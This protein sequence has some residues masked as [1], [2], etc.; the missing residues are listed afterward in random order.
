M[1]ILP[2][3]CGTE[4]PKGKRLA[5]LLHDG[6]VGGDDAPADVEA[7]PDLALAAADGAVGGVAFEFERDR[8]EVG[9]EGDDL[10][11]DLAAGEV[12]GGARFAEG[13]DLGGAVEV[14]AGAEADGEG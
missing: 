3:R 11:A 7:D 8:A 1:Q 13:F 10:E 14:F 12:C 4:V 9:A 6:D 5:Q 2:F